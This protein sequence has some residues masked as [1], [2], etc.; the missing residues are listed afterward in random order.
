MNQDVKGQL[1]WIALWANALVDRGGKASFDDVHS[2]IGDGSI[3]NWL[4]DQGADMSIIL[5]EPMSKERAEVLKLLQ[6]VSVS[7]KGR[8]RRK[9]AV[10]H[11][12]YCLLV[13]LVLEAH[14]IDENY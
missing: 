9:L 2:K 11:N 13:G 4:S 6:Q 8:E 1:M 14:A 5:S 10:Q 3:F 7:L 12:G